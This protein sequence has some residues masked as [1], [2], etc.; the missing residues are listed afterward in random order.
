MRQISLPIALIALIPLML[1]LPF[2]MDIYV[3][4]VPKITAFFHTSDALMQAY[5]EMKS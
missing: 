4:A 3:P 1:A 5:R 2:G